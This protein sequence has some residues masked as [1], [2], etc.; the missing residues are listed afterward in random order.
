MFIIRT[1]LNKR[2][3]EQKRAELEKIRDRLWED[4]HAEYKLNLL[5]SNKC[6]SMSEYFDKQIKENGTINLE[7]FQTHLPTAN[8]G[9]LIAIYLYLK[10]YCFYRER[11]INERIYPGLDITSRFHDANCIF[12]YRSQL[13]YRQNFR[14][15]DCLIKYLKS[16]R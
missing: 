16:R 12:T 4:F 1:Q 10:D 9:E 15:Y 7:R 13:G 5:R 3:V 6:T 2:E 8:D 14:N 11:A